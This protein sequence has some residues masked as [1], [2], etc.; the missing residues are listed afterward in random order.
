MQFLDDVD[1]FEYPSFEVAMAEL[2]S[3]GS[4]DDNNNNNIEE[5][6]DPSVTSSNDENHNNQ[7]NLMNGKSPSS[8][9]QFNSHQIDD[10]DD[11][12]LERL[13]RINAEFNT[14]HLA[15]K[16]LKP[17]GICRQSLDFVHCFVL[18]RYST[19]VSSDSSRS[20]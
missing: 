11:D 20:I 10:V 12:E 17:K 13:A 16:P 9:A 6:D 3:T 2:G 15:E 14:N 7:K 19:Y 4:D 1:T 8:S 18:V 5:D